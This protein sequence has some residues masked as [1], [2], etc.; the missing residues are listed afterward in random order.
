M[1]ELHVWGPAFGL[2]S[3]DAHCLAAIAY[4]QQAVP[5]TEWQLIATSDP[6]LSPTNTLPALR[7][8]NVWIGGFR[9][10]FYYLAQFSAGEWTPDAGLPRQESADCI[11]FSSFVESHGQSLL[12]LSL[13]VSSQNYTEVTRPLYNKIQP[14]PLPYLTPS[15]IRAAAKLRTDHLGL[16]SLDIDTDENT[17]S[18]EPSIIPASLRR[19]KHTVSSMLAAS[20]EASARFKLDALATAFFEPLQDLRAGKK[21]FISDNQFSSLD[22]LALGYLTLMLVPDLPQPWLA[23][24]MREKFPELCEWTEELCDATFGREKTTLEDAFLV[25][26]GGSKEDEQLK[27][28][29]GKGQLPWRPSNNRGALDTGKVFVSSLAESIPIFGQLS[30][31]R[32][33]KKQGGSTRDDNVQS[34]SWQYFGLISSVIAGLG[35]GIGYLFQQGLISLPGEEPGKSK[36][37]DL[38]PLGDALGFY[39]NG[40]G[41]A[42]QRQTTI[43]DAPHADPIVEVEVA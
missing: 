2:P 19:P 27:R 40:T 5:R 41:A 24:T 23:R 4:L 22:F 21:F 8:G 36:I 43:D 11:A 3:I 37:R 10:I 35:L 30:R 12:D 6:A 38:G 32:R 9:N 25:I 13:Y 39:G 15:S 26:P 18:P 34:S 33:T 42:I 7:N 31:S 17:P 20:P 14:F 16:S 28:L 1:L 29:R